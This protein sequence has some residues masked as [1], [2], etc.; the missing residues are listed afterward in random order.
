MPAKS[1]ELSKVTIWE[2]SNL[3]PSDLVPHYSAHEERPADMFIA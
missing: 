3:R 2:G 1:N